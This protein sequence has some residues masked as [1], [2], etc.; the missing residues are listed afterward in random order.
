[1]KVLHKPQLYIHKIPNNNIQITL[2][3]SDLNPRS[4]RIYLMLINVI[5]QWMSDLA[6]VLPY[7]H[8]EIVCLCVYIKVCPMCHKENTLL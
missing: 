2:A 3:T 4:G 8:F 5:V 7:C 6:T 1:M